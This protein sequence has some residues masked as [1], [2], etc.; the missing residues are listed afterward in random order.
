MAFAP[1]SFRVSSRARGGVVMAKPLVS[2]EL[3]EVI[4]PLLPPPK[5]RRPDHPG[6]KPL[7]DRPA[8]TGIVF[9]LKTGLPWEDLPQEMGCGCGMTCWRRLLEWFLDGTWQNLHTLLLS[10]LRLHKKIDF[11]RFLIDTSHV[12]AVGGGAQTGPSP[13][14][15]SKLGSKI[16]LITDA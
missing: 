11:A 14:D 3:W 4:R 16:E 15:R 2:D 8:L 6:R 13:V 7:D 10:R 12:R 5:P 9:V 1:L